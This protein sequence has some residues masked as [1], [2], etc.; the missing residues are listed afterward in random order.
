MGKQLI[1]DARHLD[2]V[3]V[4][5]TELALQGYEQSDIADIIRPMNLDKEEVYYILES[6]DPSWENVGYLMQ[7]YLAW[8]E[9]E[10]QQ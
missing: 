5:L 8:V 6:V 7:V 4:V 9:S 2:G 1:I 10:E 3:G